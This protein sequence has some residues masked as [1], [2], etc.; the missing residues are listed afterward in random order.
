MTNPHTATTNMEQE[1]IHVRPVRAHI[2][3]PVAQSN[4]SS[5]QAR[6]RNSMPTPSMSVNQPLDDGQNAGHLESVSRRNRPKSQ[7]ASAKMRIRMLSVRPDT[8]DPTLP[9]ARTAAKE[10]MNP[11][12]RCVYPDSAE[13]ASAVSNFPL[14]ITAVS[15]P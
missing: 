6:T 9:N 5:F 14:R 12:A 15:S 10:Q 8:G 11:A 2:V 7:S 13:E 4:V 3:A 1:N